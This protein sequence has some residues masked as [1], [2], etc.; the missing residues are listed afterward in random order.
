[1]VIWGLF[2]RVENSD[3]GH[4]FLIEAFINEDMAKNT[5]RRLI[6]YEEMDLFDMALKVKYLFVREIRVSEELVPTDCQ[7]SEVAEGT[8]QKG[9]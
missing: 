7:S 6:L 4:D 3:Y 2:A 5:K 1:M 9:E 8:N